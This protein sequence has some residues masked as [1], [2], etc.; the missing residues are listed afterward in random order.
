[1]SKAETKTKSKDTLEIQHKSRDVICFMCDECGQ[2]AAKTAG[3]AR[4]KYDS[5]VKIIRVKCSGLV[6]PIQIMDALNAGAD[7]V[8]V[9]GCCFGACHFANG[10]FLS[11]HRIK[12]L[13]K[14]FKEMGYSDQQINHY[15]ARAAEG[16]TATGDFED[17]VERLERA[18][19][20][21]GHLR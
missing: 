1:M 19:A 17:I 8:G 21:G 6:G 16:E 18:E 5:S 10:N 4:L 13:K 15:T 7:A 2:G 3:V 20:E 12:I 14:L 9:I 11:M